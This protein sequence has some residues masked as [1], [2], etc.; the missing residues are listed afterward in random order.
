[1]IPSTYSIV[2]CDLEKRE[3]GVAV[4]SKFLASG[5]VVSWAQA[6]VG[7]IATQARAKLTYGPDGL[8]LLSDGDSAE[9]VLKAITSA[10][11][12]RAE[13][14]VGIVDRQGEASAHT[15]KKCLDWA[16]HRT[17]DGFTCQGNILTG[18]EVLEAMAEKFEQAEGELV[19]RLVAAL[20]A[21]E[22]AGGDKRGKQSAAAMVVR[23]GGGYGGDNDRYLDL[24]VDDDPDPIHRLKELVAMHHVFFKPA[25]ELEFIP[26]EDEVARELQTMASRLGYYPGAPNGEWDQES[27]QAFELLIANENLEERWSLD[28]NPDL[29]DSMA[30]EYLRLRYS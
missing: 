12:D 30:L 7:A 10:D 21:G 3:W 25:I 5:A 17:G 22:A 29:I 28:Q 15:G 8:A 14:Q 13:R 18:P 23:E 9:M 26:I 11:S 4:A 2:A 16:G 20:Q 6:E 19:D 27:K 24:R 1:M